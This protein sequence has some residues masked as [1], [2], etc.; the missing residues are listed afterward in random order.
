M[1]GVQVRVV[2]DKL[3]AA[4]F[5]H[6]SKT[7]QSTMAK[8]M[9]RLAIL[10]QR[11]VKQNKL[12]GQV[13]KVRTGTLRRS[14]SNEIRQSPG[15]I[16]AIVGTNVKYGAAHEFGFS[17]VVTV[18]AHMRTIKQAWGKPIAPTQVSVSSFSRQINLPEKS[19][20][21][22]ALRDMT[23]QLKQELANAVS[24]VLMGGQL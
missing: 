9:G 5:L 20:L 3:V 12:T 18:K 19:F 14:I 24:R 23:P 16:E 6:M 13:L 1:S 22:S 17:G 7:M 21:R 4:S 11:Y 15:H 8:E 2:G 10:L